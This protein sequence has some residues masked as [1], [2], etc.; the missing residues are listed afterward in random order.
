MVIRS[1]QLR[2]EAALMLLRGADDG[3][4]G[5]LELEAELAWWPSSQVATLTSHIEIAT[6]D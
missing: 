4:S 6:E 3:G 5:T 1:A 2:G